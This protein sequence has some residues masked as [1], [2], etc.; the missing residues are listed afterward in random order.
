MTTSIPSTEH[1]LTAPDI[2]IT[3]IE[4]WNRPF[5]ERDKTFE[6][7]RKNAPLSWHKPLDRPHF[8]PDHGEP[9]F[10]A[11]VKSADIAF[12]SQ[13][14]EIF[15]SDQLKWRGVGFAPKDP[16]MYGGQNF[17]MMDPPDHTRFRQI[18]SSGFTPKAVKRLRDKIEERAEQIVARVVGAGEFDFVTE[19]ASKLPMLTIADLVGVPESLVQDFAK[20][21]DNLVGAADPEVCPEG[22][23]PVEF[24]V[25]QIE[26]L[27]QIGND[28]VD[29]RRRNPAN[30][31]ATALANTEFD[32]KPLSE[33]D[34]TAMMLLLS[35]AGNDTTKQTTSHTAMSLAKN[36]DQ[37]RWLTE[38]FDGRIAQSIEEFIRHASPVQEFARTATADVEVGG[39]QINRG[40]KLVMF[41]CS[42]NRDE[43]T[44][45]DPHRFD[46]QRSPNNNHVAFG[47]G[48]VHYCLG[49]M[50]AKAQ[51]RALYSQ[52]LTK[53]PTMEVGEPVYL[54]SEFING[55]KHL[56]VRV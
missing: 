47:G 10:W 35:V 44:F 7:L 8:K 5:A 52:I 6:W 55:I 24:T 42:G 15:S 31:I 19:V 18:I 27:A 54:F 3:S 2:D 16:E 38:D 37:K 12:V 20:A 26:I 36:P 13:N 39:R 28:L 17:V 53:L 49:H 41:Y 1:P 11:V 30:D 21:G 40:D 48:G 50:V 45:D 25:Q 22:M 33:S 29:F 56:P 14:H 43:D 32:G 51:L 46:L 4:F 34:V 23:S 9:G